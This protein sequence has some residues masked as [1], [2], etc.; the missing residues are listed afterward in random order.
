[1]VIV[2][3]FRVV[4]FGI[5]FFVYYVLLFEKYRLFGYYVFIV[6]FQNGF[7]YLFYMLFYCVKDI[8]MFYMCMVM[9]VYVFYGKIDVTFYM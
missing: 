7:G 8:I 3:Q 9:I 4:G 2:E 6:F 1:M 5:I